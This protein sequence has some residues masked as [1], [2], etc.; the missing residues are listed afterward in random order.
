VT[1]VFNVYTY[2]GATPQGVQKAALFDSA[3]GGV[4]NHEV[5]FDTPRTLLTNDNLAVLFTI[6]LA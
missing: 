6:T 3:S 2:V 4:M 1:T 5:A